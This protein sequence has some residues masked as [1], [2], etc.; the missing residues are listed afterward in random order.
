MKAP[1]LRRR[2]VVPPVEPGY[3]GVANTWKARRGYRAYSR[4]PTRWRWRA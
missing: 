3:N 2:F 1:P 4:R